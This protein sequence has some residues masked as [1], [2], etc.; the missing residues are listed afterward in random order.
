MGYAYYFFYGIRYLRKIK[1]DTLA[2]FHALLV[3]HASVVSLP[4]TGEVAVGVRALVA[5]DP[6]G[7]SCPGGCDPGGVSC[8]GGGEVAVG[9][10]TLSAGAR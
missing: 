6:G 3:A 2:W 8:P 7:V 9:W 10:R 1:W 5:C 4:V